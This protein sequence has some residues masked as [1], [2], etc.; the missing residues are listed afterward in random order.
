MQ[1]I[2]VRDL[3][4]AHRAARVVSQQMFE[5]FYRQRRAEARR[6]AVAL[7]AVFVLATL[8]LCLLAGCHY[9]FWPVY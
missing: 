9:M 2:G 8:A 7:A 1:R 5:E 4:A 6:T 3:D